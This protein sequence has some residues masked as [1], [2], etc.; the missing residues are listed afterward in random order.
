MEA[1]KK[2]VKMD[3][4][5]LREVRRDTVVLVTF[6][7][8]DVVNVISVEEVHAKSG[9][10]EMGNESSRE[11]HRDIVNSVALVRREAMIVV[12]SK[13]CTRDMEKLPFR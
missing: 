2:K 8:G 11:A 4:E 1:G 13:S 3:V 10:V 7:F 9:R 6:V 12:V 5:R